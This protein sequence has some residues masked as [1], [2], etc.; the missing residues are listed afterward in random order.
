MAMEQ[1]LSALIERVREAHAKLTPLEIRGGGSKR[2]LAPRPA[3]ESASRPPQVAA[4]LD[5]TGYRGVIEYEPTELVL[6]VR[7]GTPL[8]EVRRVLNEG[9]QMLPF[10]PPH[11]AESA[12]IG[13]CVAAGLSG[14]RR[15]YAGSVRDFVLGTRIIDGQGQD[16]RFGGKVIKNVAGYD[17][18][19]L[20]VGAF[21]TLGVI[22]EISFKVLPKP[23]AEATLMFQ[24]DEAI[25]LERMN[26]WAGQPLPLSA[27]FY[28]GDCLY[29]RLSGAASAVAAACKQLGGIPV[30]AGSPLWESVREQT[31]KQFQSSLPFW[32]LSLP[33]T[34]PPMHLAGTQVIEWGGA[35]RWLAS[36]MDAAAIRAA[37]EKVGGTAMLFRNGGGVPVFH[38]LKAEIARFNEAVKAKFD[39]A[40][41][42][43]PGRMYASL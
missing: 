25:A 10:E 18:S 6:S 42:L 21:G 4:P 30:E 31:L 9:G 3:T 17:V 40:H 35:L 24:V 11:F 23:A 43:N 5:V 33:S 29:V 1:Q 36:D 19:R 2:F 26:R 37:A 7:A 28:D 16:L 39:P 27:T 12:T 8:M 15:A 34:T 20:M 22:T 38:P 41:I 32:R 13:G 14:P